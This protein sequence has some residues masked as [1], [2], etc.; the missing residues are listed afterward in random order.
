MKIVSEFYLR[1]AGGDVLQ[2]EVV[3]TA[4]GCG[5]VHWRHITY[6]RQLEAHGP[7]TEAVLAACEERLRTQAREYLDRTIKAVLGL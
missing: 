6:K 3:A 5:N 7:V 2:T 4:E 1:P